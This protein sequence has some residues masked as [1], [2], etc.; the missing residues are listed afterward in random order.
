M[1]RRSDSG[2]RAV[3]WDL[4]TRLFHWLLVLLI[5]AAWWS[6]EQ[7]A[8]EWHARIGYAVLS[9]LFFRLA[10]GL[11]GSETSR[12]SSFIR[13]PGNA[14]RYI[15]GLFGSGAASAHVGHNPVGGYSVV[16]M[17]LSLL[18]QVGTGLFLYD[19]ELFW[20]PLNDLVSEETAELL[21]EVHELNFNL[22]L[23]LIAL[24]VA[25]ILYYRFAKKQDLVSPM[26][27]GT[28]ELPQGVPPPRIVS[29]GI[30]LVLLVASAAA[31]YALVT[32]V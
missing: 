24:H 15:R 7:D 30:A 21:E 9:L 23:G 27:R 29:G 17:L 1:A 32:F 8:S 18:V 5:A 6:Q 14:L 20:A 25:A 28:A 26:I 12:F 10:W 22:L 13:G 16:L 31:V 3:I 19:D 2:P 4:P 11:V